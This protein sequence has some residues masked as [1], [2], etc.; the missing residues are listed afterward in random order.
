MNIASY[1]PL[2][3]Q[4]SPHQPAIYFK[5]K[6][7]TYA[8][9]NHLCD[10]FAH[11]LSSY[12]VQK[13]HRIILMVRP[14]FEFVA[15]TFALLKCGASVVLIDPGI[16]K[17]YLKTAIKTVEPHG[18]IGIAKAHLLRLLW[19]SS[20]QTSRINLVIGRTFL[21]YMG[22]STLQHTSKNIPFPLVATQN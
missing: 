8:Q 14:G 2:R 12:G 5:N 3:A 18:F 7:L 13:G 21:K 15:L 22:F 17:N 19:P 6:K 9:L 1:L 11:Q 20:F 4:N 10:D 16:G